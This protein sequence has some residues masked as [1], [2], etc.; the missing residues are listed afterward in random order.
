MDKNKTK[1]KTITILL[2]CAAVVYG[3]TYLELQKFPDR[4][5][6][7]DEM[8]SEPKQTPTSKA[9]FNLSIKNKEYILHPLFEY[10]LYGMI[11]SYNQNSLIWAVD[12]WLAWE[13]FIN[14]KDICVIWG[15]N[16]ENE[17]YEGM[18]FINGSYTCYPRYKQELYDKVGWK[19]NPY[20]LSNNHLLADNSA[21][22]RRLLEAKR[23]DQIYL[24]GYLVQ[25]ASTDGTV[26]RNTSISRSDT[27]CES[28]YVTDFQILKKANRTA[29]IIQ[30]LAVA[31]MFICLSLLIWFD[32]YLTRFAEKYA[33]PK[34]Y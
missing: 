1:R 5:S 7:L 17:V 2:A 11:V 29:R 8:S 10:E 12:H 26:L 22:K 9:C 24:K 13:D 14:V 16:I 18:T 31:T 23:G 34:N 30:K 27:K 4:Y 19:Y 33:R 32:R 15:S 25:Y 3:L 20:Q 6:M 21:I 28:I